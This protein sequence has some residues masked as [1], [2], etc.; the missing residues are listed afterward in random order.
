MPTAVDTKLQEWNATDTKVIALMGSAKDSSIQPVSES[1]H[2]PASQLR[3]Q[4]G[5]VAAVADQSILEN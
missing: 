3:G 5:N 4:D 2:L 1:L